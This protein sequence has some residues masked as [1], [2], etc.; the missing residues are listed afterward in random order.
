MPRSSPRSVLGPLW[1]ALAGLAA[2]A[3]LNVSPPGQSF[4]SEP[5]GARVYVDG[6]DSGWVT[7]CLVALDE[8]QSHT[9]SFQLEGYAARE[10]VLVPDL[11]RE[12]IEWQRGVNG[13]RSTVRFPILLPTE[14]LLLPIREIRGLS[15]GRVFVR[16]RPIAAP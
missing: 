10:V 5:S 8:E 4:S 15:P 2:S 1:A 6:R 16:L 14:D 13:V 11:R 12:V 3:C 7:P 9:I